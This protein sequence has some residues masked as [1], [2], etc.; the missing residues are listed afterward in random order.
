MLRYIGA[1]YL[2]LM[3]M[4][5]SAEEVVIIVHPSNSNDVTIGEASRI[6]SGR[7]LTFSDGTD[8]SPIILPASNPATSV[9]NQKVF[10]M[11]TTQFNSRISRRI[12]TTRGS[13][14]M[15]VE[16]ESMVLELI[17][18][19]PEMIGYLSVKHLDESV[20]VSLKL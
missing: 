19:H 4:V 17:A 9:F 20:R 15:Q 12:F 5:L 14:S 1:I 18:T 6:F 7:A 16:D 11:N 3:S 2:V 10:G 13:P 8:A